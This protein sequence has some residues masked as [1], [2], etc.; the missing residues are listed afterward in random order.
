MKAA[1]SSFTVPREKC[2]GGRLRPRQDDLE[3]AKGFTMFRQFIYTHYF[4]KHLHP[5]L[6][7]LSHIIRS[8]SQHTPHRLRNIF[9]IQFRDSRAFIIFYKT[10]HKYVFR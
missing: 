2:R 4:L 10:L 6:I 9:I 3:D 8:I 5:V 7:D 1:K